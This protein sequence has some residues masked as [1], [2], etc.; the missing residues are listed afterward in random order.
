VQ[1]SF[2]A[3]Q[4]ICFIQAQDCDDVQKQMEILKKNELKRKQEIESLKAQ[5]G[6]LETEIANPP[7]MEDAAEIDT[8][9][10]TWNAAANENRYRQEEF[11]KKQRV[12]IDKGAEFKARLERANQECVPFS[13]TYKHAET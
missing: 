13:I 6:K 10:K 11:Q 12:Y 1:L 3:S 7:E 4:V 2:L 5:I 9:I 8:D